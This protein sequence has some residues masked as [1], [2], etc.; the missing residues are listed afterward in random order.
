MSELFELN[1]E[2]LLEQSQEMASLKAAYESLFNNMSADL[3]GINSSWSDLLSNNF[4]GKIA[5]AQK[6][7]VGALNMLQNSASKASLV[8][9]AALEMDSAM[10]TKLSGQL[11]G[12]MYNPTTL[13]DFLVTKLG[14][15]FL[16]GQDGLAVMN[17]LKETVNGNLSSSQEA[18]IEY[19]GGK[20]SK[21]IFGKDA[22]KAAAITEKIFSGDIPGAIKDLS[23]EFISS[24]LSNVLDGQGM[25]I[26]GGE[27]NPLGSYYLNLGLNTG[28]AI[29]EFALDPSW[30]NLGEIGWN[31]TVQPILD[32]AGKDIEKVVKL[33]PGV[34]DYYYDEC[35]AENIGDV[36][37]IALG[38]FYGLIT[39]DEG[40]REY[41]STYYKDQG[42]LWEGLYNGGEEVVSFIKDSGGFGNAAKNFAE[43]AAKDFEGMG[44][45]MADN[46]KILYSEGKEFVDNV[47]DYVNENGGYWSAKTKFEET[48]LKD[49]VSAIKN[50]AEN[51]WHS[52]AGE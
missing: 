41:A 44:D 20:A 36:A 25:N 1:P 17:Q 43:T 50:A 38:D 49:G 13:Q 28:E 5:S 11:M 52:I 21:E 16:D 9:N 18:W 27:Y 26:L 2:L 14:E 47:K 12:T 8:A 6:S 19:L 34:S 24:E 30:E 31:V 46:A 48:A 3:Q 39:G 33:V 15:V 29:A 4:T 10:A 22:G 51:I 37:N 40:M 23:K 45:H 35:G 32:T 42:G 7:F